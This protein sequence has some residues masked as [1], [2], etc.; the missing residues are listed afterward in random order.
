MT[1]KTLAQSVTEGIAN[2]ADNSLLIEMILSF[3]DELEHFQQFQVLKTIRKITDK[4]I[5]RVKIKLKCIEKYGTTISN[6]G[7]LVRAY[8]NKYNLVP[9]SNDTIHSTAPI[10]VGNHVTYVSDLDLNSPEGKAIRNKANDRGIIDY[11]DAILFEAIDMGFTYYSHPIIIKYLNEIVKGRKTQIMAETISELAYSAPKSRVVREEDLWNKLYDSCFNH[12]E[13]NRELVIAVLQNFI[14]SV[15]RKM[16]G[17]IPS[18]I[19]M[20]IFVGPQGTGKTY[21]IEQL[22]KP[23]DFLSTK[24]SMSELGD[25]RSIDLFYNYVVFIDEMA[26]GD[27][28]E[29]NKAKDNITSTTISGR[30]LG[31]SQRKT[32]WNCTTCI[33]ATNNS[34][35]GVVS[36]ETGGRR[37]FPL[38]FTLEI[39]KDLRDARDIIYE[40]MVAL[41]N[42]VDENLESP[43][44]KYENELAEIVEEN[45]AKSD[46]E[47]WLEDTKYG[48]EFTGRVMAKDYFEEFQTWANKFATKSAKASNIGIFLADFKR[49]ST[50]S[51]IDYSVTTVSKRNYITYNGLVDLV[52][53]EPKNIKKIHD[54]KEFLKKQKENKEK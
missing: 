39:S 24:S 22:I 7:D 11:A 19:I 48:Q 30:V 49:L 54:M 47:M 51:K 42:S 36:D 31:T 5:S 40:N 44:M 15:K 17:E 4:D 28:T 53:T 50:D 14:H 16:L 29:W 23:L 25:T 9:Q 34:Y 45:R 12:P 18:K 52:E 1:E 10:L 33:G 21:F 38:Y 3:P 20:P 8:C 46:V 13:N 32:I 43:L 41:W 37:F 26:R 35:M 6:E 27:K 2:G